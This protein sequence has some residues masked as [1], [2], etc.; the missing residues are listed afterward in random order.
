MHCL[1]V[2]TRLNI[3]VLIFLQRMHG[4]WICD[5]GLLNWGKA[6]P[7][8]GQSRSLIIFAIGKSFG[9]LHILSGQSC[10]YIFKFHYCWDVICNVLSLKAYRTQVQI[11]GRPLC[12]APNW[13]KAKNILRGLPG[14]NKWHPNINVGL[15]CSGAQPYHRTMPVKGIIAEMGWTVQ[16]LMGPFVYLALVGDVPRIRTRDLNPDS[17]PPGTIWASMVPS[18]LVTQMV[19]GGQHPKP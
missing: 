4:S 19:P 2:Y 1:L 18:D 9:F 15:L 13:H 8:A 7:V 17:C 14:Q 5:E 12:D 11:L 6:T 10:P 3:Q 16:S